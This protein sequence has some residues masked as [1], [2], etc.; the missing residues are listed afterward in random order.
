MKMFTPVLVA[1]AFALSA[2]AWTT[3]QDA[4]DRLGASKVKEVS[5]EKN[6]DKLS[7][8]QKA[9]IR[10]A[11]Q[12]AAQKGKIDEVKV[13][14][15]SDK[16]YPTENGKQTKEEVGLAKNRIK[17]LKSFL[18]EE[19]KVKNIDTHNMAERPNTL[20]KMFNTSDAKVKN[21][22]EASGAAPT[23]GNTGLFDL[24][25]QASKG[26]VMVFLKR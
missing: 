18:K 16:E 22:T 15:W 5:F 17:Y 10:T 19:L 3:T 4:A 14:A 13:L 23:A 2:H 1:F 24:K 20:E 6:S 12:E 7:D 11:I 9:E 26:V 8:A 25:A 21:T